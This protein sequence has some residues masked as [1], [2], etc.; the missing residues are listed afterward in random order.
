M[1]LR[2]LSSLVLSTTLLIGGTAS[3]QN[4]PLRQWKV[5]NTSIA[6]GDLSRGSIFIPVSPCR[7]V[8]TRNAAGTFGGPAFSAGTTR[9]FP[10]PS[11][12]CAGLPVAAAYSF[13]F[14]VVNY[15]VGGGFITVY[16]TGITR[17]FV[18]TVNFGSGP[19][20]ANAAI[21]P[22]G[23][24]SIDV[25]SSD[26]TQVIIDINGYYADNR[27]QLNPGDNLELTG[28]LASGVL[29]ATNLSTSAGNW[30][31]GVTGIVTGSVKDISGVFGL[32]QG[33][34]ANFGVKGQNAYGDMDTAG[35]FGWT[36][37]RAST[38]ANGILFSP[39]G[40]RGEFQQT[41]TNTKGYGLLG[42]ST[43]A[44]AYGIK[45][46]PVTGANLSEGYLGYAPFGVYARGDLGVT[47]TKVIID[48]HP[49]EP[50]KVIRY[51]AMEGP[52]AGTYFRGRGRFVNH[53][54][55]IDVPESFRDVTEEEGMTVHITPIG[56]AAAVGVTSLSLDQIVAE[57]T[58]DV[59]FSYIVYGVRKGYKDF[60]SI[61]E[62]DD[63]IPASADAR[64]PAYLN[65]AQ[66]Q[67]LIDNGTYN[68]DGTVNMRTALRLGWD[69][70][71]A[72]Q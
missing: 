28:N 26:A 7:V 20:V 59:E 25:Y 13:N 37:N 54:A 66:K 3:A 48:P 50:T 21:V 36:V 64:M 43:Y 68:A 9:S 53:Q 27:A 17:P 45:V 46:D 10:I 56:G 42:I 18:S 51:A 58:R 23:G 71:W 65:A 16:P 47:G 2:L 6:T 15:N 55:V 29:R 69:R 14:T 31:T 44:G 12:P 5:P 39:A 60:E 30:T 34:G 41:Q 57:S 63:F 24:G 35:V 33:A 49:T 61:V 62:S 4:I 40:V 70:K 11:G 38:V 67:R 8:D 52:E 19:A 32:S 22:A 72:R 1:S